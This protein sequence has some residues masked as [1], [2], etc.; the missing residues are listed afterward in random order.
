MTKRKV[1]DYIIKDT[2]KEIYLREL[3]QP[4]SLARTTIDFLRALGFATYEDAIAIAR[5]HL[6]EDVK[7]KICRRTT[8][9]TIEE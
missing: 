4:L 5:R 7:F 9:A 6:P 3:P 1:V 2:I 8:E